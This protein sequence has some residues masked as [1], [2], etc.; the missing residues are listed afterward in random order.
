M[1]LKGL[2]LIFVFHLLLLIALLCNFRAFSQTSFGSESEMIKSADQMFEDAQFSKAMPLYS[3]LVSL[4]PKDW[5]YNMKYG[6]CLLHADRDKAACLKY[7]KYAS[8]K[9][10]ADPVVH[11]HYG[12][13]LHLN[14]ELQKAIKFYKKFQAEGSSK[15]IAALDVERNIEMCNNGKDL[16]VNIFDLNV[17]DKQEIS[18]SEFFRIYDLGDIG[19]KIIVKP[20]EFKSKLDLKSNKNSLIYLP[21]DART[22]YFSGYGSDKNKG[23][24]IFRVRKQ[25]SGDWSAPEN[26]GSP[27][28][29][30]FDED[31]PFMHPDGTMYFASKGHNSMGGYDLFKSTYNQSTDTWSAPENLN[32]AI[33]STFDDILF[34]SDVSGQLA[35]FASDRNS[36]DGK[37]VVYRVQVERKAFDLA[38]LSGKFVSEG[39]KDITSAKISIYDIEANEKVGTFFSDKDDG[40]YNIPLPKSGTSYKFIVETD[41]DSP[42]HTG[43]V[44][45]PKQSELVSLKQEIRL[46][47][48]GENQK[49]VI[50][51][52]FDQSTQAAVDP[53]NMVS[54]L[55]SA[56]E[57]E[58]NSRLEDIDL[59][60]SK[61]AGA[62]LL[63]D[64]GKNVAT[65]E[66]R[67]KNLNDDLSKFQKKLSGEISKLKSD[68]AFGYSY[69][70]SRAKTADKMYVSVEETRQ[71]MENEVKDASKKQLLDQI[72]AKRA[73]LEPIASDAI[74]AYDFTLSIENEL[75]E[76]Q[77]DLERLNK[78]K[79]EMKSAGA[80]PSDDEKLALIEEHSPMLTDLSAMRSTYDMAP[81]RYDE[82]LKSSSEKLLKKEGYYKDIRRDIDGLK[83]DLLRLENE[84]ANTGNKKAKAQLMSEKGTKEID[85][86]DLSYEFEDV[87]KSYSKQ[88]AD[89]RGLLSDSKQLDKFLLALKNN[90]SVAVMPGDDEKQE[91]VK[92]IDYFREQRYI[93]DALGDDMKNVMAMG[94]PS[95][96]KNTAQFYPAVDNEG[97]QVEYDELYFINLSALEIMPDDEK[98]NNEL[99]KL[100]RNW[101]QT[102]S[103]DKKI[104]ENQLT[105]TEKKGD[106]EIITERI[107][108]L[109]SKELEYQ[110][111]SDRYADAVLAFNQ[112]QIESEGNSSASSGNEF[113]NA[114]PIND[115]GV[116]DV[117]N[118]NPILKSLSS[119]ATMIEIPKGNSPQKSGAAAALAITSIATDPT[120]VS[121]EEIDQLYMAELAEFEIA[122]DG[123]S[124]KM[125]SSAVEL[126]W[127]KALTTK[128]KNKK[129]RLE[130]PLNDKDRAELQK[131]ISELE[132]TIVSHVVKAKEEFSDF[133][134]NLVLG[135]I[136]IEPE[137]SYAMA[138]NPNEGRE[139]YFSH[140]TELVSSVENNPVFTRNQKD[141]YISEIHNYWAMTIQE[142][143]LHLEAS[144]SSTESEGERLY[145]LEQIKALEQEKAMHI[146]ESN[147]YFDRFEKAGKE[148]YT[149]TLAASEGSKDKDQSNTETKGGTSAKAIDYQKVIEENGLSNAQKIDSTETVLAQANNKL[150]KQQLALLL[151]LLKQEKADNEVARTDLQQSGT[152]VKI[153]ESVEKEMADKV[154][155]WQ[156][157]AVD[158]VFAK[159]DFKADGEYSAAASFSVSKANENYRQV[160]SLMRQK[161]AILSSEILSKTAEKD[162]LEVEA[163][164]ELSKEQAY[165]ALAEAGNIQF[166][167]NRTL[168]ESYLKNYPNLKQENPKLWR[169]INAS[170]IIYKE[171]DRY[172]V[173][174]AKFQSSSLKF[175]VFDQA[176][177]MSEYVLSEQEKI[178]E[179]LNALQPA[180]ELAVIQSGQTPIKA[181]S[182]ASREEKEA[183]VS[184]FTI[185]S[186][187]SE[188]I[189]A[190]P[191]FKEYQKDKSA[192]NNLGVE[193][194]GINSLLAQ[195]EAQVM[196]KERQRD[197]FID[198]AM[199]SKKS[200]R[201][202]LM[203][204]AEVI[205]AEIASL[206]K[207]RDSLALETVRLE[208]QKNVIANNSQKVLNNLKR[209]DQKRLYLLAEVIDLGIPQ[210]QYLSDEELPAAEKPSLVPSPQGSYSVVLDDQE[211][212]E[213]AAIIPQTL[214]SDLFVKA[215]S[216]RVSPY[217]E[218][219][220]IP[221]DEEI[222][223]GL[224]FKV[225]IG[226]FR[227]PIPQDLFKGFAPLMGERIQNGITRYTAGLFRD[228]GNANRA[229]NEI[230]Q[231][232]YDDAFVVAFMDGKRISF[233][234]LSNIENVDLTIP[235]LTDLGPSAPK[236]NAPREVLNTPSVIDDQ[237]EVSTAIAEQTINAKDIGGVFFTVQVGVYTNT[238]LPERL[239]TIRELNSE[240]LDNG[241]IRYSAGQ[242]KTIEQ[243]R[244]R[245]GEVVSRGIS[246]AFVTA[247]RNGQRIS[248][249]QALSSDQ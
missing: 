31:Y 123:P 89:Y 132:N 245:Q 14:Y 244:Q 219:K 208:E 143:I 1:G 22:L 157:Q 62:E 196:D 154:V 249:A 174:A 77:R 17:I 42:V 91:L 238:V 236:T 220:P 99:S 234:E 4:Y 144:L 147:T 199:S 11:Y 224:V 83:A 242:F 87:S 66:V 118:D 34:I 222:P 221:V 216:A 53:D 50:K 231:L 39:N 168:I 48:T 82:L 205:D 139:Q 79:L 189:K 116:S 47:G 67:Y 61:E 94:S 128:L 122:A 78:V 45:I 135:Q 160:Q 7:L 230:R 233:Q 209:E 156:D 10:D 68:M 21:P 88:K 223:S 149:E 229:K 43:K 24:D 130:R 108:I 228:F 115:Q 113:A 133:E 38:F 120:S 153:E 74:V 187:E 198:M 51:N 241:N 26:I 112:T 109:T 33:S 70:Y 191:E 181:I 194:G 206:K 81:Q 182:K 9:S 172:R 16:L 55:R 72:L 8:S 98:K 237:G 212:I 200:K 213:K 97:K 29:T 119:G 18:R 227:N 171:V 186:A 96:L 239:K 27:L 20:D 63:K 117:A 2:K 86:E 214:E 161:E 136:I 134:I 235:P 204:E 173:L 40:S 121:I 150:Q 76:K 125:A 167:E 95:D 3:Q 152:E 138:F 69:S 71:R 217:N 73:E 201:K 64:A 41:D 92:L 232:G 155:G 103:E 192:L 179:Q 101:A 240:L 145:I 23:L 170:D 158:Y 162:L 140:Y 30:E 57:L 193:Q 175:D 163:K 195:K 49:L 110:M 54:L 211:F 100:Y 111:K 247:Y 142:E 5:N 59:T 207:E 35:Y 203:K 185:S 126:N 104:Q 225:Q 166:A 58:V 218:S 197:E 60:S 248:V 202:K 85:L 28:N 148:L 177:F 246:D 56:S 93:E 180:G 19:G 215:T 226:A 25:S 178:I 183:L 184:N 159:K 151:A 15:E 146:N 176:Q 12:R 243:A 46:V 37:I 6:V 124:K 129:A 102:V 188:R 90:T 105:F 107:D 131:E 210:D 127:A 13:G 44:D 106:K 169:Q 52:L 65:I 84:I 75:E 114:E 141:R 165:L 80:N 36:V 32:F 137:E 164:I 190:L